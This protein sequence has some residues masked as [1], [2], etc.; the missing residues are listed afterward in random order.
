LLV[1]Q[2]VVVMLADL[3][4]DNILGLI[5]LCLGDEQILFCSNVRLVDAKQLDKRLL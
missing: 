1:D 3:Q 2:Y 4:C 5:E